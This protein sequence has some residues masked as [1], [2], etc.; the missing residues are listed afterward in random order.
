MRYNLTEAKKPFYRA[1][2][3]A[4]ALLCIFSALLISILAAHFKKATVA[5]NLANSITIEE[6]LAQAQVKKGSP[7]FIRIIKNEKLLELYMS[8]GDNQFELV[9]SYP[10]CAMSGSLGPKTKQGDHQAPEGFYVVSS[11][12]LNP[13]S[14]F[15]LSFNLGY[16]N[17]YDRANGYTGDYLMVHGN[18]VSAGCFAMTDAG[19]EEIYSIVKAA[20]DEGQPFFRVHI[21]PFRMTDANMTKAKGHHW[22]SFWQMLKPAYDFFELNKRPPEVNVK[23]GRYV[24]EE[25]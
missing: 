3:V 1:S 22:E 25:I 21:F 9:K 19:I 11:N 8:V 24:I 6:S 18:C 10:V 20:L 23:N 2:K 17:A 16:P 13:N 5:L 15:H 4:I 14:R 7:V 12:G